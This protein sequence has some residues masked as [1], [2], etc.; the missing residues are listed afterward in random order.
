MFPQCC[1]IVRVRIPELVIS[2]G[3]GPEAPYGPEVQGG[4]ARDALTVEGAVGEYEIIEETFVSLH[5][6]D[7]VQCLPGQPEAGGVAALPVHPEVHD[8]STGHVVDTAYAFTGRFHV[9]ERGL[10]RKKK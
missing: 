9:C 7:E 6:H 3:K 4:A 5:I 1:G 8:G 2:F 10:R